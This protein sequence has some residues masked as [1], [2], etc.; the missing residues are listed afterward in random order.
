MSC[1]TEFASLWI[2]TAIECSLAV[3][4][5]ELTLVQVALISDAVLWARHHWEKSSFVKTLRSFTRSVYASTFRSV[6]RSEVGSAADFQ[7]IGQ[8][9]DRLALVFLISAYF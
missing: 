5:E 4:M 2:L 6:G 1:F 7:I 3:A 8:D 9:E